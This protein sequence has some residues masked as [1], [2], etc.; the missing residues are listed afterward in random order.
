MNKRKPAIV[1][2]TIAIAA[3]LCY[4]CAG[5]AANEAP[6]D[7]Q[8]KTFGEWAEL[9]PLQYSSFATLK[10]KDNTD[11]MEGHYALQFKLLAPAKADVV[12]L[13]TDDEGNYLISGMHYDEA[14]GNWVI[15]DDVYG[16][17]ENDIITQG[18]FACKSTN[19]DDVV[20]A[21]G[22]GISLTK[23]NDEFI[24]QINA[25]VW[26]CATCHSDDPAKGFDANLYY[27]KQISHDAAGKLAAGDRVCG[28]CHNA[29]MY[30][31]LFGSGAAWDSYDPWKYGFDADSFMQAADEY[32]MTTLDE[33]T[34]IKTYEIGHTDLEFTQ[35]SNHSAL[36]ITCVDCHMP[37][38][39]DAESG[40]T[41][42]D[43]NASQSPLENEAAL[44][45]CLTCHKSQ[46]IGTTADM[47]AMV[48]SLQEEEAEAQ[49]ML[50]GELETLY[51]AI[52]MATQSGSTD[53]V[54]LDKARTLYAQAKLYLDW[55]IAGSASEAKKVVHNPDEAASLLARAEQ[56]LDEAMGL[57][58]K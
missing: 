36:G 8:K 43:H 57:M 54:A 22:E 23:P 50:A 25:Q 14:T 4:G 30:G 35:G 33:A 21:Q 6:A 48:K 16:P 32:E 9:Y 40:E 1:A 38:V 56:A 58:G 3:V 20:N 31:M 2:S 41:Y 7:N 44:E 29:S 15:D 42:T 24:D 47:A 27:F 39:T 45:Y 28:Q 49:A 18:C 11:G 26:D 37:Q 34:G 19:F 13:A 12:N 10:D 17:K 53:E 51:D 52:K 55:G 5:A 46:G